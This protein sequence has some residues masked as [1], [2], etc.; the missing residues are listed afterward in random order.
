MF[1]CLARSSVSRGLW[2]VRHVRP[3]MSDFATPCLIVR[4][5]PLG[6]CGGCLHGM[7]ASMDVVLGVCLHV[8]QL[9]WHV[10]PKDE[11]PS[12]HNASTCRGTYLPIHTPQ[13]AAV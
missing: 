9:S 11:P 3:V 2:C 12:P 7:R 6:A 5:L 10:T 1:E 8:R 13:M 4:Q